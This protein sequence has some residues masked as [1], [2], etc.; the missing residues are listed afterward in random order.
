MSEE[1]RRGR[2][3]TRR[4]PAGYTTV[5]VD[6]LHYPVKIERAGGIIHLRG[7]S[8]P[9][10]GEAVCFAR[11]GGAI[12]YLEARAHFE[13]YVRGAHNEQATGL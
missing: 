11:H 8:D 10:S 1:K 7:F 4:P 5:C 6:G 13:K 2:G 12:D 9:L 3:P